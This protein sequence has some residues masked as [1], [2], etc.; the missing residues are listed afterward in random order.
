[1]RVLVVLPTYN[2]AE[3]IE[4]VLRKVRT[5]LPEGEILVV[6]DGSPDGTAQIAEKI[7]LELGSIDVLRRTT[8]SGLG[9]AYRAG[10]TWGIER[11]VDVLVE[12]DSDLSHDPAALPELV[13][14]IAQGFDLA[15]GSRYVPGGNIPEW[16]LAR[17]ILSRGGNLYAS[18]LLGLRIKDSTSGYRA[19]SAP[20]LKK[21]D[22]EQVKA[23]GYGFQIEMVYKV[24]QAGGTVREIPI[25]FTDRVVGTSKMSSRIV[26]EALGLVTLWAVKRLGR[27]ATRGTKR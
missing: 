18:A 9:T 12:M 7:A 26:V 14:P 24:I 20:I 22:L 27:A 16:K 11:G 19:Y 2:E 25:S 6:D 15:V 4:M 17:R 21:V 5:A 13:A 3:N 23:E 10:F 8:K 1:V